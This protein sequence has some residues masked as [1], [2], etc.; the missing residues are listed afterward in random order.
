MK[1]RICPVID[2]RGVRYIV[3]PVGVRYCLGNYVLCRGYVYGKKWQG[4]RNVDTRLSA[5]FVKCVFNTPA[6]AARA[7]RNLY[8]SKAIIKEWEG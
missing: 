6:E 7:V 1:A 2:E 5:F 4:F 8:G 3:R